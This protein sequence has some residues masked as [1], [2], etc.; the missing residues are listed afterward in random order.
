[1]QSLETLPLLLKQLNL[2]TFQAQWED[3]EQ[4]SIRKK[5]RYADY[6]RVLCGEEVAARYQKRVQRYIKESKLPVGK[7][8]SSFDFKSAPTVNA[9]QIAALSDT[10]DWVNSAENIIFFG[11]SGVGKTHLA[12]AIGY[13]MIEHGHRVLFTSTTELV[14]RLERAK[15][16]Y[17]LPEML[18]K[19]GR[20][21]LLILDDIGYVKKNQQETS[22]LFELIAHRYENT[23]LIIT[24]NQPFSEWSSIFPD[25]MM[26]VAAIDRIVHHSNIIKIEEDSWRKK[27]AKKTK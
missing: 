17:R 24:S 6:L 15:S 11:P 23:S 4:E 21:P 7:T 2:P 8:L 26:A 13:R 27:Q 3:K 16:E 19:L 22:V 14:Q 5:W 18:S 1:M 20:V 9:A 25:D 12:S 10:P